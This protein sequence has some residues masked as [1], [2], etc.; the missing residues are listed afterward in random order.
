MKCAQ[1]KKRCRTLQELLEGSTPSTE[2]NDLFREMAETREKE[3]VDKAVLRKLE[4]WN[5]LANAVV[6]AS[7]MPV[8]A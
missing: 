8:S 4:D 7:S 5:I 2:I 1:G 6:G 3:I